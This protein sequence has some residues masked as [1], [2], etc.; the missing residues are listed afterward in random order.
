M[1]QWQS[2]S[3]CCGYVVDGKHRRITFHLHCKQTGVN[4]EYAQT[5]DVVNGY[6]DCCVKLQIYYDISGHW[7]AQLPFGS[8][9]SQ[10]AFLAL[11]CTNECGSTDLAVRDSEAGGLFYP[12][13]RLFSFPQA[14]FHCC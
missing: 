14:H 13:W 12:H 3:S 10:P 9:S 7:V 6:F 4:L 8:S 2:Q 5:R 1:S 11:N